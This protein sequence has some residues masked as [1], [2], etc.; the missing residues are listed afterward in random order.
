MTAY[1]YTK[2]QW[3]KGKPAVLL[4]LDQV[5]EE[6]DLLKSDRGLKYAHSINIGPSQVPAYIGQLEQVETKML[7]LLKT[8]E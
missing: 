7:E 6:L 5:R 1:D 2:Q 3:V 4:G 8:Y